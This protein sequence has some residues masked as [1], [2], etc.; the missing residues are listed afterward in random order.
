MI[1]RSYQ[2]FAIVAA[3]SAQ[4]LTDQLNEKLR[5]LRDKSPTVTFEGMI[6]RIQYT[7]CERV[8][9]SLAEEYEMQGVELTCEDCPY[10]CPT[11][12]ADGTIDGRAKWG[13]C[14]LM[15]DGRTDK[16]S[17]ACDKLFQKLNNGEIKLCV[18]EDDNN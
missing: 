14:H 7:E 4:Q 11:L 10:F 9:E 3:D 15:K 18:I 6:A 2:Q 1:S 8:P 16:R 17:R 12:K 13:G 5:E